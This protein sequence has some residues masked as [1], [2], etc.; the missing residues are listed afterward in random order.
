MALQMPEGRC[1]LSDKYT[2]DTCKAATGACGSRHPAA[3][4]TGERAP[5]GARAAAVLTQTAGEAV[6][7]PGEKAGVGPEACGRLRAHCGPPSGFSPPRRAE[8]R[9]S[10]PS[11]LPDL[12]VHRPKIPRFAAGRRSRSG[13]ERSEMSRGA[14]DGRTDEH[15]RFRLRLLWQRA[16]RREERGVGGSRSLRRF[17]FQSHCFLFRCCSAV[18]RAHRAITC[19]LRS[20]CQSALEHL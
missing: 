1:I 2:S 10:P 20:P 13:R 3:A 4:R 12:P 11:R 18:Q 15:A 14:A 5:L 16:L 8:L 17:G 6:H 7:F 9:L 19:P